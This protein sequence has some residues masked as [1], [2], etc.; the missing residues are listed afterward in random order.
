MAAAAACET[1][2]ASVSTESDSGV[3][4]GFGEAAKG[5]ISAPKG[6]AEEERTAASIG[7][8]LP[9]GRS[10]LEGE[11]EERC[12]GGGDPECQL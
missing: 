6:S 11:M 4:R 5:A 12:R 2:A 1:R 10:M 7:K 3:R 8:R 9:V